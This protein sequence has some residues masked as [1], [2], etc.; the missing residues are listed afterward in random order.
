MRGRKFDI[1]IP[2]K[3]K[4]NSGFYID[5]PSIRYILVLIFYLDKINTKNAP[6]VYQS[7]Y[8]ISL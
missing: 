5:F 1:I 4:K 2:K 8:D 6:E 3:K 7:P